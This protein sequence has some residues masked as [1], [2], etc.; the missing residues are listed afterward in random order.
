MDDGITRRRLLEAGAG[1][2]AA[3]G[4]SG[5][6]L[7]APEVPNGHLFVDNP[8]DERQRVELRVVDRD[9]GRPLAAAYEVPPAHVLQFDDVL[10]A[11]EEYT[12]HA[13]LPESEPV[14]PIDVSVATCQ[15]DDQSGTTDVR[16]RL[17]RDTVTPVVLDC[18]RGY[19]RRPGAEYVEPGEYRVDDIPRDGG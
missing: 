3:T 6:I 11:D 5:C 13:R 14:D 7:G 17:A 15:E 16:L 19:Q 8:R 9:G 10:A 12:I 1:I 18:D 2:G 4:L